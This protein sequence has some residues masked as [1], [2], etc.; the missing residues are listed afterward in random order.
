VDPVAGKLYAYGSAS[1][2]ATTAFIIA[3]LDGSGCADV[4]GSGLTGYVAGGA[5]DPDAGKLFFAAYDAN[6]ITA[7]SLA[8]PGTGTALGVG[9]ASLAQASYPVVVGTPR[10]SATLAADGKALTCAA[11]WSY[12]NPGMQFYTTPA[13]AT[14]YAWKRG[15]TALT[16][17]TSATYTP[18]AA[19]AYTCT[20]TASN[21]A[22]SGSATSAEYIILPVTAKAPA[23]LKRGKAGKLTVTVKNPSALA[24]SKVK[25]CVKLPKGFKLT[26]K[27]GLKVTGT[28]ACRTIATI[29]AGKSSTVTLNLKAPTKKGKGTY[30]I[31]VQAD[32]L[33]KAAK[34]VK[35]TVK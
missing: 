23:T 19:G 16:G 15:G 25:V 8:A 33:T 5:A 14:S 18:T 27:T 11:S 13:S 24:I 20:T 22:G 30:T 17:A 1:G 35:T 7:F 34:T 2:G 4:S 26:K 21:F 29:A 31:T 6:A 10:G 32:G 28:T 9:T 12:G 3:N